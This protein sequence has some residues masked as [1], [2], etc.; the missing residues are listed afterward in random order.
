MNAAPVFRRMGSLAWA[1]ARPPYSK[2]RH[3]SDDDSKLP[4]I[5]PISAPI[6]VPVFNVIIYVSTVDGKVQ[7]RVANLP[8]LVYTASSEPMALKQ[9]ITEVKKQ[10]AHWHANAE[11]IPWID[12]VPAVNV[13]EQ[14]RLV[15]VHL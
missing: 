15:P 7:A 9:A 3:V 11:T 8:D 6:P 12:P 13:G 4:K 2:E 14:Q 1:T 10:L 5:R